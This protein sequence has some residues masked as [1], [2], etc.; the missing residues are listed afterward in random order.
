MLVAAD[1]LIVV[2]SAS[3]EHG[4]RVR[5]DLRDLGYRTEMHTSTPYHATPNVEW[6]NGIWDLT[7][8]NQAQTFSLRTLKCLERILYEDRILAN[9]V[10]LPPGRLRPF[11]IKN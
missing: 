11:Q 4:D 3:H 10:M 9:Q 1:I 7:Y 2:S 8:N 5:R 6:N